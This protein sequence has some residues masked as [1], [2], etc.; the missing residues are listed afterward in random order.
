MEYIGQQAGAMLL[1]G[2][3]GFWIGKKASPIVRILMAAGA[4]LII[5]VPTVRDDF[6]YS[7]GGIVLIAAAAIPSLLLFTYLAL[8]NQA[9]AASE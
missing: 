7:V 8:R 4:M 6:D 3:L 5:A 9:Q 2:A 1:L